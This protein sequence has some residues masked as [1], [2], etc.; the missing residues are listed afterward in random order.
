MYGVLICRYGALDFWK[1]VLLN[2]N[3]DSKLLIFSRIFLS[4][5]RKKEAFACHWDALPYWKKM[6]ERKEVKKADIFFNCIC[7][8]NTNYNILDA[9]TYTYTC[10]YLLVYIDTKLV[11]CNWVLFY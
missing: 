1:V 4:N 7:F 10:R 8:V 3:W 2:V 5:G 11:I 9:G 6:C